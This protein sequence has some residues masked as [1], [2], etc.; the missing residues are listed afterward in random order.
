MR[1]F[2]ERGGYADD[3]GHEN[4]FQS[5]TVALNHIFEKLDKQV[6][7]NCS[8]RV[9]RECEGLSCPGPAKETEVDKSQQLPAERR[10]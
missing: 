2:L 9:F 5:K 1:E 8:L 10:A 3:I 7:E 6:C 4:C